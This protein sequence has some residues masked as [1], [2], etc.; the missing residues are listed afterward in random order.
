MGIDPSFLRSRVSDEWPD[1]P[2][3]EALLA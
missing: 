3:A 1:Y 2:G